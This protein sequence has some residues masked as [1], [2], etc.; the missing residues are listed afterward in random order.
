VA[1]RFGLAWREWRGDY[2]VHRFLDYIVE[3]ESVWDTLVRPAAGN[4]EIAVL[5]W[6]DARDDH[7][8]ARLL[9]DEPPDM[10][11]RTAI[12]VCSIDADLDCGSIA[13]VV[14]RDGDDIVW[15]DPASA[16]PDYGVNEMLPRM[17]MTRSGWVRDD[18]LPLRED[19]D[20]IVGAHTFREGFEHWPELRFDYA[21]YRE[22]IV[23]RPAPVPP[24]VTPPLP[25]RRFGG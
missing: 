23:N 19:M 9:L 11:D 12:Y 18:G 3:G 25:R 20:K 17:H 6:L 4:P 24:I 13:V 2:Q 22:A 10:G 8:A 21:Q 14:E 16:T 1:L 15:L 7:A 5:G